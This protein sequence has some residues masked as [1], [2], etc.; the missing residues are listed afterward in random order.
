[1]VKKLATNVFARL[2]KAKQR[3]VLE[4]AVR[5]FS[6]NGYNNASMNKLTISAG[7]S[8]GSIFQYFRNKKGLFDFVISSA[9]KKVK[10]HLSSIIQQSL[11]ADFFEI[12]EI[13]LRSG[14]QFIDKHPYLAKIYYQVL[15]TGDAPA[16]YNVSTG[17]NRK[18]QDFLKKQ[19]I[20]GIENGDIRPGI[21]PAKTAFI[22]DSVFSRLLSAYYSEFI[23]PDLDLYKADKAN[24]DNWID[25]AISLIKLGLE[26]K[27][28]G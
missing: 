16:G 3:K 23:A 20:I 13:L 22:L 28:R 14:F 18:A 8:K 21:N 6:E 25:G 2:D 15:L 1:M 9:T 17:L 7:I 26:G 27:E 11:D 10:K 24:L 19:I 12:L 5:E 4:A